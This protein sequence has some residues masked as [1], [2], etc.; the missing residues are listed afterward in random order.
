MAVIPCWAETWYRTQTARNALDD[1]SSFDA[2]AIGR[3]AWRHGTAPSPACRV[4]AHQSS[5]PAAG[6]PAAC[7][8][9]HSFATCYPTQT[10]TL[11]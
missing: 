11:G 1:G 10:P 4:A 6:G 3:I 5:D 9:W 7:H 2:H 8:L